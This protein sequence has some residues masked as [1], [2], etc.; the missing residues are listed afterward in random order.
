MMQF[1]SKLFQSTHSLFSI[2]A[3]FAATLLY[4]FIQENAKLKV[5]KKSNAKGKKMNIACL[6]MCL[7]LG[8]CNLPALFWEDESAK[9]LE[10]VVDEEENQ[11]KAISVERSEKM[12]TKT[13][14]KNEGRNFL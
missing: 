12:E 6:G 2:L 13:F 11:S 1:F 3:G 14:K 10:D 8:S 7:L 4:F 5:G 9:V